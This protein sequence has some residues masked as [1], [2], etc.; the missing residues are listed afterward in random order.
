[1]P[2]WDFETDEI[3]VTITPQYAG[4]IWSIYD[5]VRQRDVLF[6]NRAHQPANIG[7]LKSW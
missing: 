4:K 1:L 5:K 6:N 7:A 2:A 3:R